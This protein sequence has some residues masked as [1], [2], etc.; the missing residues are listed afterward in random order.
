MTFDN[1]TNTKGVEGTTIIFYFFELVKY[2]VQRNHGSYLEAG[3]VAGAGLLGF[4][5]SSPEGLG[6]AG[7]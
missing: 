6:M 7:I 1:A 3:T 4:P 5:E 2:L